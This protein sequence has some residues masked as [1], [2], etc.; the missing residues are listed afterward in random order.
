MSRELRSIIPITK[1]KLVPK[2]V[3]FEQV[4]VKREITQS[5]QQANHNKSAKTLPTLHHEDKVRFRHNKR[6]QHGSIVENHSPRSYIVKTS[7]G[8]KY[9][10][11]RKHIIRTRET[12]QPMVF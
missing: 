8:N 2:F 3:D 4:K 5:R 11:N 7:E 9:R 10:R 1:E 6:W 12:R